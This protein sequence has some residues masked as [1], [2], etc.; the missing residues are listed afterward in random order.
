MTFTFRNL[1]LTLAML[2]VGHFCV[3]FMIGIWAIYKTLAGLDLAI[4]GAVAGFCACIGEG[5]QIFF[6]RFS[7]K[8]Y[9]KWVILGGILISCGAL[10]LP[11]ASGYWLF[12]IL[13]LMTC[14]GSGAFHPSAVGLLGK[15]AGKR[16][17]FVI[18]IFAMGGSLG[19]AFSHFSF[20]D[21]YY[22]LEHHIWILVI[23]VLLF[24]LIG[25]L[26]SFGVNSISKQ[27]SQNSQHGI[28]EIFKYFK[29]KDLTLVYLVQLCNQTFAW[30]LLFLLPDVLLSRGY[31]EWI[32]YGGDIS[33]LYWA[34]DV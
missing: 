18:S 14:I 4:A 7:D 24:A 29:R 34:Q 25:C 12:F 6:G 26:H 22:Y 30:G 3:D 33:F 17:T 8:G 9:F 15:L 11:Y 28:L 10:F 19:L 13:Y 32:T 21:A 20:K 2:F 31:E 16:K 5:T 27:F 23:P 1:S